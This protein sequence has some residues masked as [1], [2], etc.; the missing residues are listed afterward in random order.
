MHYPVYFA[1]EDEKIDAIL[2]D[3]KR[4]DAIGQ[5]PTA[6]TGGHYW[7]VPYC[8]HWRVSPSHPTMQGGA[9]H[10]KK[11]VLLPIC[12]TSATSTLYQGVDSSYK[13]KLQGFM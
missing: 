4:K 2:A 10:L 7:S 3:V 13:K 1:F 5:S 9:C 8:N 6:T 12:T 11:V